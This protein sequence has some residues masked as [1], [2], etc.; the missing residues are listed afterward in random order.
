MKGVKNM[1]EKL[2]FEF[3][4][5]NNEIVAEGD[6]PGFVV[7]PQAYFRG[8]M[9]IPGSEFNIG[10][11]IFVKPF[12]LDR[13]P[14]RHK[15]DEYLV[16]LGG[17]FPNVFNFDA[18]IEFTLG[19][20]G[21]DAEVFNIT[22]PTIIRVPAGVYHCPLNFKRVDKPIFFQAALFEGMFGGIYDTPEGPKEMY[23]NGPVPCKYDTIKK[24]DAC[25]KCLGEDWRV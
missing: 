10:F 1:Y 15:K 12:F 19:Q 5:E 6:D 13:V 22:K 8:A 2:V 17:T 25:G 23:Y 14:H 9:Q 24:C 21:V 7:K 3:P 18:H 4:Q 11:Q 20:V 16:F